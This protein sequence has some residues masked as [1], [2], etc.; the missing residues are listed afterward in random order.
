MPTLRSMQV[1]V[2]VASSSA[3]Q[4]Q[5]RTS[6]PAPSSVARLRRTLPRLDASRE[7]LAADKAALEAERA[8]LQA[9]IL[10]LKGQKIKL[11]ASPPDALTEPEPA[12][13]AAVAATT[14]PE[15]ASIE[16]RAPPTSKYSNYV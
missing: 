16:A 4:L 7:Q 3:L 15:R 14:V 6:S 11:E 2:L 9:E 10:S 5:L 12:P 8:T 13:P 1:A